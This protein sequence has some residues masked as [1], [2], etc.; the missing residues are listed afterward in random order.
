MPCVQETARF[1]EVC[2]MQP[3]PGAPYHPMTQGKIERYH[4]SMKN[5]DPTAELCVPMGPAVGNRPLRRLLQPPRYHE[6]LDNVMQ[7]D[8]YFERAKEVQLRRAGMKRRTLETR[9]HQH[10]QS[11]MMAA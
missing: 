8:V 2:R 9:R 6:S 3:T 11:L 10:R 1:L 4:R 5:P 7:V